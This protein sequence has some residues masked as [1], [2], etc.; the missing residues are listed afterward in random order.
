MMPFDDEELS[1]EDLAISRYAEALLEETDGGDVA[2][3]HELDDDL[4]AFIRELRAFGKSYE[5]PQET[6]DRVG[7]WLSS[8]HGPEGQ[9]RGPLLPFVPEPATFVIERHTPDATLTVEDPQEVASTIKSLM[10]EQ[11]KTNLSQTD[12]KKIP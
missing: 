10:D 9:R 3:P 2:V 5:L 7:D 8:L 12:T 4:A 11:I 6:L 1:A